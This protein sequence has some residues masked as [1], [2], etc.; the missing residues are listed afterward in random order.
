MYSRSQSS[1]RF[2]SDSDQ[3]KS[4][5]M[6]TAGK[7][8]R[9]QHEEPQVRENSPSTTAIPETYATKQ[10]SFL[11]LAK[12]SETNTL[13]LPANKDV[14]FHCENGQ[15]AYQSVASYLDHWLKIDVGIH[16]D[17]RKYFQDHLFTI[18]CEAYNG[19]FKENI[20]ARQS[21]LATGSRT[22]VYAADHEEDD[23]FSCGILPG[24]DEI[25]NPGKW[26]GKNI[27][28]LALMQVRAEIREQWKK[29]NLD[30]SGQLK[31]RQR[32]D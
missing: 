17:K 11:V 23:F 15:G 30:G 12:N 21:L 8:R 13:L 25:K 28:G 24:K 26:T 14:A 4:Y 19:K 9:I 2:S 18:L 1:S 29:N 31:K 7:K 6:Y 20:K 22:I 27:V 10:T 5:D 16:G 32:T 3:E